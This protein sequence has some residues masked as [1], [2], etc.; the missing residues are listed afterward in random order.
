MN[1]NPQ[2]KI[3]FFERDRF[4]NAKVEHFD[5]AKDSAFLSQKIAIIHLYKRK[6]FDFQ[7]RREALAS[8]G[9][10]IVYCRKLAPK[11]DCESEAIKVPV[12]ASHIHIS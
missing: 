7:L 11:Q 3:L 6:G 8:K 1:H 5:L 10:V 2:N 4:G 12:N 9:F